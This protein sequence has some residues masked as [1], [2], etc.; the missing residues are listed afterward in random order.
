MRDKK[1]TDALTE[2]EINALRSDRTPDLIKAF[3]ARQHEG[4]GVRTSAY[5]KVAAAARAEYEALM[6]V[7][8]V[9]V[10]RIKAGEMPQP[11][12]QTT[13]SR[14]AELERQNRELAAALDGAR[15]ATMRAL[16]SGSMAVSGD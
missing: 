3:V 12:Q 6:A 10:A 7:A 9:N 13:S 14:V 2:A 16:S 4:V 11:E 5:R 15:S 1:N 8:M